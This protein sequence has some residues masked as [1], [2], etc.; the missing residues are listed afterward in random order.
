MPGFQRAERWTETL[1]VAVRSRILQHSST[2]FGSGHCYHWI[3]MS[4]SQIQEMISPEGR[5]F[6]GVYICCCACSQVN[7][8]VYRSTHHSFDF[9]HG[10]LELLHPRILLQLCAAGLPALPWGEWPY[11]MTLMPSCKRGPHKENMYFSP[12]IHGRLVCLLFP[13][14]VVKIDESAST[15]VYSLSMHSYSDVF[16]DIYE[17]S[18]WCYTSMCVLRIT[19]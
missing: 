1:P 4:R 12:D 13:A 5:T 10:I 9:D 3:G 14:E 17:L 2:M 8:Q 6:S 11:T 16:L 7:L 15:V 19:N 18:G